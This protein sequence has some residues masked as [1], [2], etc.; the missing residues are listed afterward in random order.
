MTTTYNHNDWMPREQIDARTKQGRALLKRVKEL[1][2]SL[3]L[4]TSIELDL[5]PALTCLRVK[6]IIKFRTFNL[7]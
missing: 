2:Q 5:H 1:D 3:M 6:D 4:F 7:N